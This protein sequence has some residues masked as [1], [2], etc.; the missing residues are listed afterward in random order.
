MGAV[1]TAL[2]TA[3]FN[4]DGTD[5][6]GILQS[7]EVSIEDDL[8]DGKSIVSAYEFNQIVKAGATLRAKL[9]QD[10]TGQRTTSL[11]VTVFSIDGSSVLGSLESGSVKITN[12]TADGSGLADLW[13]FPV[14]VG[15]SIEISASLK[16]PYASASSSILTDAASSAVADRN[17]AFTMTVGGIPVTC[18]C[19]LQSARHSGERGGLQMIDV[20]LKGRGTPSAPT[21]PA[22][23]YVTAITGSAYA[24]VWLD[25]GAGTYGTSSVKLPSIITDCSFTFSNGSIVENDFT[26][27]I[28]GAPTY[29][30]S[31]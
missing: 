8:Q 26:F 27:A 4:A 5:L 3:A 11:D 21:S 23:I 6:L 2:H 14:A 24:L 12:Q 19:I 29:G 22:S 25:T 30:A 16:I 1:K 13:K 18:N 15:S 31:S 20:V 28:Q 9:L 7:W 17:M 10:G